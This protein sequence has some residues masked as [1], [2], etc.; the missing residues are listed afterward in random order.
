MDDLVQYILQQVSFSGSIGSN[1]EQLWC[2]VDNFYKNLSQE[3][4]LDLAYK[5]YV[6][7]ILLKST[8]F[9]LYRKSHISEASQEL[10]LVD[11]DLKP[12][13]SSHHDAAL[14]C[15]TTEQ[16]QWYALTGHGIDHK[17]VLCYS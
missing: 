7:S 17:Q 11:K 15:R 13:T 9:L 3:H 16:R 6:W 12:E 2:F 4:N 10:C 8:D 1:T 14:V 5:D